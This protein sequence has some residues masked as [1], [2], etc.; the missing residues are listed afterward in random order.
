MFDEIPILTKINP[1]PQ[2]LNQIPEPFIYNNLCFTPKYLHFKENPQKNPIIQYY[3]TELNNL[4]I[5]MN[6]NELFIFNSWHKFFKG[7]NHS[8]YTFSDFINTAENLEEIFKIQ[9]IRNSKIICRLAFGCNIEMNS[10]KIY[11][12]WIMYKRKRPNS[13]T[14]K[15]KQYGA[16]FDMTDYKIKGY[17]KTMEVS[18]HNKQSL[19]KDLFRIE[20]ETRIR[21]LKQQKIYI[22]TVNDLYNKDNLR[23]LTNNL[24]NKYSNIINKTSMNLGYLT[25]QQICK[26][27]IMETPKYREYIKKHHNLTFKRFFKEYKI[28]TQQ[29]KESTKNDVKNA[30]KDKF[31]SL[32]ES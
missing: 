22:S 1:P 18:I 15:G 3:Y 19:E 28:I 23:L 9:N 21:H 6:Y 29:D 25:T 4:R 26:M 17:N 5:Q 20:F 32:I 27:A 7:N 30:I 2:V 8:D 16:C 24:I 11:P 13:M 10:E 14:A 31:F 12:N